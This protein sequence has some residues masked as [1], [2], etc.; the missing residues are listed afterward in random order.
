MSPVEI[1]AKA[2][3]EDER[4]TLETVKTA[5]DLGADV[6]AVNQAGDTVVHLLAS[7]GFNS[8]IQ[9][10]ADKGGNLA[11]KNRRGLTPL[12]LAMGARPARP[13]A[14]AAVDGGANAVGGAGAA[15]TGNGGNAGNDVVADLVPPVNAGRLKSTAD[16]LRKLGATQ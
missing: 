2:P 8:V 11:V 15:G 4:I 13:G 14:A 1:A 10:V 9:F 12:A 3:D 16:L 7:A 5:A 6:N